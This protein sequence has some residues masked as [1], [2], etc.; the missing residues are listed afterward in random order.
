MGSIAHEKPLKRFALRTSFQVLYAALQSH[1]GQKIAEGSRYQ[2]SKTIAAL[3][4]TS[5]P[6]FNGMAVILEEAKK[7]TL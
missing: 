5:D 1:K 7:E 2:I 4:A 6:E 3:K